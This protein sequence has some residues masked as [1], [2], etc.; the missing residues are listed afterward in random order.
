MLQ[1]LAGDSW[2][3]THANERHA[4]LRELGEVDSEDS[5]EGD[6]RDGGQRCKRCWLIVTKLFEPDATDACYRLGM[7][8]AEEVGQNLII[9]PSHLHPRATTR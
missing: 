1:M 3:F 7:A 4:L 9:C 8:N 5:D 2:G 6:T